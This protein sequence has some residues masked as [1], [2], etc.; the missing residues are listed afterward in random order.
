MSSKNRELTPEVV[1]YLTQIYTDPTHPGSYGGIN[2]LYRVVKEEGKYDLTTQQIADFLSSRDEYTLHRPVTH[3]F[4]THHVIV[5]GP[6][7]MHQGDLIDMGRASSRQNDGVAF[8]LTVIDCFT[9][10]AFVRPLKRKTGPDMVAAL[11]DIYKNRDA[12]TSFVS[13]AGK[14]F[15]GHLT[16]KWFKD[17]NIQFHVAHGTHKAFFIERFNRS[18]K[19]RLS[20]YMTQ[21]NTLRYIDILDDIVK[22]YNSTYNTATGYKPVDI[23]EMNARAVFLELYG[24]PTTWFK[25]LKKPKFNVGDTVRITR[26]KGAFEK[27]YEETFTREVYIVSS[28]LNT[29]PR[30]YKLKSLKDELIEG[31]FY[32]KE[33]IKVKM[34]V[35]DL[36]QIEK[37]LKERTIKGVKQLFVKWKGWDKS[38]NQ[39]ISAGGVVG[40]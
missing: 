24:S 6:N 15:V 1:D 12:P 9:R 35:D 40:V 25:H 3:R 31:R 19:S 13:D 28:V 36:Y 4:K 5:G 22:S 23:N 26:A 38:H 33:M 10:M 16:Q 32:E 20:K 2:I 27:G 21:H 8:L 11:T 39:W 7:Q 29:N 18:V 14:E 37:V 34:G 30:E 17:N